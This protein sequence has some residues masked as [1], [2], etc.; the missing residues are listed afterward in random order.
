[1]EDLITIHIS[2]RP[3]PFNFLNDL[4]SFISHL[5]NVSCSSKSL[6]R[7]FANS[8]PRIACCGAIA[9]QRVGVGARFIQHWA[10]FTSA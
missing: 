1:M 6:G 3:A 7:I 5:D 9:R 10:F 4:D 2:K 8:Q